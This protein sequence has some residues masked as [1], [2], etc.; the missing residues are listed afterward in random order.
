M[1]QAPSPPGAG[2]QTAAP[3]AGATAP[4]APT[5]T[6]AQSRAT[7]IPAG[8]TT[9]AAPAPPTLSGRTSRAT[10]A[11]RR[12]FAGTPGR[13]RLLALAAVAAA[14]AFGLVAGQAFRSA[15]AGL[16][17]AEANTAQ[18][19]RIQAINTNLM[20]ADA[21][22]TNA[23]L[24]GG[25]EPADR[26][27]D[28]TA[29][30]A[31]STR[32]IA[33]A[34]RAQPADGRALAALNQELV[35]YA[36]LVESARANNRQGL[37]V[38]AQYLRT[39]SADLRAGAL[40]ILTN[41]LDANQARAGAE[42]GGVA[43]QRA[44]LTLA[45]LLCLVVLLAGAVWLARRTRRV[46]NV[47]LTAAAV[48]V[49]LMTVLGF[50]VLGATARSVDQ[51]RDG[52]YASALAT[53][54]ARIAAF[55]AKSN[56]SLTLIA[57]GSGATFEKAWQTASAVLLE[58]A[59]RAENVREAEGLVDS[60][61]PYAQVHA[62]I[63]K[64]DDGGDWE[65]AVATATGTTGQSANAAFATFD[66]RSADV[67]ATTSATVTDTLSDQRRFLPYA[68]WLAV[69]VGLLAALAAWWGISLRLEEY[70]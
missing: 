34:A 68:G 39:A 64:L 70:R 56:E 42:F 61:Q 11:A 27:A 28:Y 20:R 23:F 54:Q 36:T 43:L 49:L 53:A 17:R 19:V 24:L 63:R 15:D 9:A 58:G 65:R 41:L 31:E 3:P 14:V 25:L 40:P 59:E 69:L 2:S 51:V 12:A 37:P 18:L 13:L 67:L 45:G 48:G 47:P 6:A 44:W 29:A 57:R 16:S 22:A 7:G 52:A 35:D 26:R 5:V 32:L 46:V 38:G 50:L 66:Q 33:E 62:T 55:D 4:A 21:D 10:G 30:V 1:T 60:W 8:L